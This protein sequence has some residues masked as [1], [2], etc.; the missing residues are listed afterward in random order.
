MNSPCASSPRWVGRSP[1]RVCRILAAVAM[2][3]IA[4]RASASYV[5]PAGYV[6]FAGSPFD[7]GGY[8]Y[9]HLEDF[10]DGLLN[11]PGVSAS[12]NGGALTPN[13]LTD[14]VDADDGAVD[15]QGQAGRS[16]YSGPNRSIT[17][18]FVPAALGGF[19]PTHAGIVWTD[20]GFTDSG[21][22]FGMVTFEA[23]DELGASLGL[24][25]PF[26]LGDGAATGGTTEDRFFGATNAT[27]ISAIQISMPDSAD[28]E[29]DHLQYGYLPEPASLLL[30]TFAACRAARRRS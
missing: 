27:G 3:A 24:V 2:A 25:G 9:F 29:V 15:G 6:Q 8:S 4:G 18:S 28:W 20:V 16:L 10:E 1:I 12:A 11:T 13:V 14:S 19:Y 17:F 7:A 30:L 21:L 23:F 5:G 22:G 26:A